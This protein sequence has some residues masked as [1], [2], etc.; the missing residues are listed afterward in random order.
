MQRPQQAKRDYRFPTSAPDA[1]VS[2]GADVHAR[3]CTC[4]EFWRDC[5]KECQRARA[6]R[7]EPSQCFIAHWA[8]LSPEARV[9]VSGL[10][11]ALLDGHPARAAATIGD[12]A[13]ARWVKGNAGLP[14]WPSRRERRGGG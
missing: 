9:W 11:A 4:L 10:V 14:R 6:C 13:L 5:T 2:K 3:V 12:A 8:G 1:L 7:I